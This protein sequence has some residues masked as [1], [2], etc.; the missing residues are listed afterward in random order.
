MPLYAQGH[1][2]PTKPTEPEITL[3]LR[4]SSYPGRFMLQAT[5]NS[6]GKVTKIARFALKNGRLVFNRRSA[7]GA[8]VALDSNGR[9]T[10]DS[11][12]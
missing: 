1:S 5:D 11:S 3:S 6:T 7:D 8:L 10:E 2:A 12:I 4:P 9:I